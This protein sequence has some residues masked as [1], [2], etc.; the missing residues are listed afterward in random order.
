M[1]L[2]D[3]LLGRTRTA[4]SREERIFAMSTAAIGLQAAGLEPAGRIGVLFKRLPPGRFDQLEREV[5]E[6][7]RLQGAGDRM[8][9][10]RR[11][12]ELGYDWLVLA[13]GGLEEAVAAQHTIA[14]RF[15]EEGLGDLLLACLF[16]F[17]QE[18]RAVFWV[19]SYKR[20]TFYPFVPLDGR[21]HDTEEELRLAAMAREELPVEQDQSTWYPIWDAPV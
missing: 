4:R 12:D 8:T 9:V 5:G 17:G 18:G 15:T 14:V 19:Y 20:S 16:R 1:G 10:E 3:A 11:S 2:L 7:L 6:L 13:G 21:R